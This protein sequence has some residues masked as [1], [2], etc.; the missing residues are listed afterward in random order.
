MVAADVAMWTA[1]LINPMPSLGIAPEIR[2]VMLAAAVHDTSA[3]DTIAIVADAISESL[4]I[5]QANAST[6]TGL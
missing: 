2:H 6:D 4:S 1:A 5:M 3:G